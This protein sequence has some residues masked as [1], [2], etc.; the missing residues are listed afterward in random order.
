MS[1]SRGKAV[2]YAHQWAHGR[3]PRYANFDGM[4]GDCTNFISQ[5]LYAG[6]GVMN[7]TPELGWYYFSLRN[8]S[9]AWSGVP[10]LYNFLTSNKGPGPYGQ[11]VPLSQVQVGDVIQ[12][13]FDGETFGHS[14]LVVR[15]G[16]TP[17]PENI[18]IA[19]HT[20]DSENRPLD[21][22]FYRIHRAIHILGARE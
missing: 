2:A 12:L 8:R 16:E 22:Y 14:L 20:D 11:K 13:S 5:C 9:A 19:A 18:L 1:Y 7:T 6:C 21:S 15:T 4:G 17:A 3:N 10:Y